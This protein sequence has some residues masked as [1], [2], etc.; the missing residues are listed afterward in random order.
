MKTIV[1]VAA[2]VLV[3]APAVAGADFAGKWS[4]SVQFSAPDGGDR[5]EPAFLVL[6][7]EGAAVTGTGGPSESD[8]RPIR[9]VQIDGDRLSFDIENNA[10]IAIHVDLKVSGDTLDGEMRGEA[11]NGGK[12]TARLSVKRVP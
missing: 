9:N 3:I 7:Q 2:V 1:A 8:Q 6:K 4:G 11:P 10:G 5:S 12:R